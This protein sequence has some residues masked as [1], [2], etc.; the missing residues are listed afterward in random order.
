MGE[1]DVKFKKTECLYHS[2]VVSNNSNT[3]CYY[4]NNRPMISYVFKGN[5]K[6]YYDN[7]EKTVSSSGQDFFNDY[8]S[9]LPKDIGNI[10]SVLQS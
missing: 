9:N 2:R 10:K 3:W 4:G 5:N 7:L 8:R 1:I 6:D